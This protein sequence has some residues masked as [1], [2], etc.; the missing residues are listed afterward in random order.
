MSA[1][2]RVKSRGAFADPFVNL[3]LVCRKKRPRIADSMT[4]SLKV[5]K[6]LNWVDIH[7]LPTRLLRRY[8]QY[9]PVSNYFLYYFMARR[10]RDEEG[11]SCLLH[12]QGED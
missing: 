3:L 9:E 4:V 7:G 5:Y 8:S 12:L 1:I 2:G 6:L 11:G 10:C